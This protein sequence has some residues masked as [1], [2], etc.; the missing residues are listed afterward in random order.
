MQ[1]PK[2]NYKNIYIV[3]SK[4]F[5]KNE[6][7]NL[8][9]K[10]LNRDDSLFPHYLFK[11]KLLEKGVNLN[12]F[13]YFNESS[14]KEPYALIFFDIPRKFNY[15]IKK[16]LEA[17][18]YLYM[19]ESP[20]KAPK[21]QDLK[22]HAYFKKIF[23]WNAKLADN[24]K[25]FKLL[26]GV[27]IPDRAYINP[28]GRNRLCT[29]IF[30]HKLQTHPLELYTERIKAIRWFEK[31]HPEDFDLYGAGWDRYYF[32]DKFWHLN[33]IKLLTKF[34]GKFFSVYP[35]Y[36]G[37]AF[38]KT[39]VYRK[40]KFAICYENAK[41]SPGYITDKILD[42]FFSGCIPIY[43]GASDIEDYIPK[44]TFIDKRNFETYEK[45][46]NFIKNM[47]RN[48]YLGYLEAIKNFIESDKIYPFS[49]ECF[50]DTLTKEILKNV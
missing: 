29:A 42:C 34:L 25:Y 14:G 17:D 7:F 31:N 5:Y 20:I 48:K 21:N 28:E 36:K 37:Q 1:P 39:E 43:W 13:D 26:Y 50:S 27:K 46:Y 44:N 32:K 3:C 12:T 24:K 35:S 2:N 19:Y 10:R 49:A 23:T 6:L 11:Q 41:N 22:N 15:F 30:G 33:R 18:K 4:S 16:H 8:E 38:A 40:Y 45:L 9:N 47:P